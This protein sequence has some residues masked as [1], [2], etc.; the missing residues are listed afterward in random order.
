MPEGRA[1]QTCGDRTGLDGRASGLGT[2]GGASAG[3]KYRSYVVAYGDG[4]IEGVTV[5][6]DAALHIACNDIVA[7]ASLL[8]IIVLHGLH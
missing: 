5:R 6:V 8:A 2:A 3:C 1:E 7:E 4:H